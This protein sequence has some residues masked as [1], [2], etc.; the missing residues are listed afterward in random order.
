MA[1]EQ[2]R[3]TGLPQA[4][5]DLE[6]SGR[7]RQRLA[8]Q[9]VTRRTDP[10]NPRDRDGRQAPGRASRPAA[11]VLATSGDRIALIGGFNPSRDGSEIAKLHGSAP[12]GALPAKDVPAIRRGPRA[13]SVRASATQRLPSVLTTSPRVA[14]RWRSP[15]AAS[16]PSFGAI[17]NLLEQEPRPVRRGLRYRI[18]RLPAPTEGLDGLLIIGAVG[19]RRPDDQRAC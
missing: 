14:S 18:H 19:G 17:I 6:R 9:R 11:S 16:P 4:C 12:A 5:R 1:A 3:S 8:V 13:A 7:R 10:A 15:S 2:R